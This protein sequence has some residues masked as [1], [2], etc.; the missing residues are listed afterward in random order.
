M[1]DAI[2]KGEEDQLTSPS[3]RLVVGRQI[4]GGTGAFDVIDVPTKN[5][6]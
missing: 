5:D 4:R 1:R 6:W 2:L 3:S